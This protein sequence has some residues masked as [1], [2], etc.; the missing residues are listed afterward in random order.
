MT[1]ETGHMTAS[2]S[3]Y[4]NEIVS[5]KREAIRTWRSSRRESS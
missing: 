1:D 5:R 3:G 4:K 2:N